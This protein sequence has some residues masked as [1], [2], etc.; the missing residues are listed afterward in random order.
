MIKCVYCE[1]DMKNLS[2]LNNHQK[3]AKY[4]LIIQGKLEEKNT[5]F[6]QIEI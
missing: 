3:K 4:C 1:T 6:N 5:E 2:V